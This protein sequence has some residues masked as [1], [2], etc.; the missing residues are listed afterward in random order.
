MQ[1][2]YIHSRKIN[3]LISVVKESGEKYLH[4]LMAVDEDDNEKY[5][6]NLYLRVG[7]VHKFFRNDE[8]KI[9]LLKERF[10]I[11]PEK[12]ILGILNYIIINM[13]MFMQENVQ[14]QNDYVTLNINIIIICP[15][16]KN[17][18]HMPNSK[19]RWYEYF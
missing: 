15:L 4:Y 17:K 19:E 5:P 16:E 14:G 12:D 13:D 9:I 3:S 8:W 10:K 18:L 7:E 1:F 2:T 6:I 11:R